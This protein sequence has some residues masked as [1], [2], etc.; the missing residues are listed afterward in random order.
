MIITIIGAGSCVFTRNIVE[1][2]FHWDDFKDYGIELRLM[3]IST[4]R[5]FVS[6]KVAEQIIQKLGVKAEVKAYEDRIEALKNSDYVFNTVQVGG[7]EDTKTDFNI[8]EKYGLK[9]TIADTHGIGG[10]FRSIRT[11]PVVLGI[12]KDME[13]VCPEAYFIN[14]SNPMSAN[15]S[16]IFRNSSIKSV[17][18]CHSVNTTAHQLAS[19][20]GI[21][22]ERITYKAAGINHMDFF[23]EFKVDGKDAYDMLKNAANEEEI[24]MKDPVRFEIMKMF[25]YFVSESSEHLSEYVPYFIQYPEEIERLNI[26]IREYIR[27]C[28]DANKVYESFKK[29]ANGKKELPV[30]YVLP[31]A[32]YIGAKEGEKREMVPIEED[33]TYPWNAIKILHGI[34]TGFR[35]GIHAN[36]K[37]TGLI[38]NLPYGCPCEVQCMVDQTGIHPVHVGKLPAQISGLIMTQLPTI[39]LTVKSIEEKRRDYIYHAAFLDPVLRSSLKKDEIVNMVNDFFEEYERYMDY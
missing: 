1:G 14:Y 16:A 5:L 29:I 30:G 34:E 31:E 11:I 28:K 32:L 24:F 36:V 22:Y 21:P 4:E 37:N 12:V 13:K 25:G 8:P 38:E 33:V 2:I 20:I 26:P 35:H 23:V 6:K 10:I 15:V 3:D 19:Y 17:G 9:Q 27:R 18:L 7:F 39:E